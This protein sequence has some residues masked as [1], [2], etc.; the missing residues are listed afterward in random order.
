MI[1]TSLRILRMENRH[2]IHLANLEWPAQSNVH[3]PQYRAH[4]ESGSWLDWLRG[5]WVGL[6]PGNLRVGKS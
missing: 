5:M 3:V 4:A 6:I 2:H 1:S